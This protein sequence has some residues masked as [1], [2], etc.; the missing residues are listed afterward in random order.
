MGCGASAGSAYKEQHQGFLSRSQNNARRATDIFEEKMRFLR[1]VKLFNQL[2]PGDLPLIADVTCK[3]DFFPGALVVT[4]GEPGEEFFIIKSGSASVLVTIDGE[5]KK[6]TTLQAGDYFGEN[7]LLRDEPRTASIVA[8]TSLQTFKIRRADFQELG[9]NSKLKFASRR[10]IQ[11]ASGQSVK[12]RAKPPTPKTEQEI[13]FI[14]EALRNSDTLAAE[15]HVDAAT[16]RAAIALMWKEHFMAGVTIIKENDVYAD[17]FYI[18][19]SGQLEVSRQE[20]INPLNDATVKKVMGELRSGHIF[21]ELALM[22]CA[23]RDST[24]TAKTNSVV[25]VLDRGNFRRILMKTSQDKCLEYLKYLDAVPLLGTLL[26]E[27][28]MELAK[29]LFE[30]HFNKGE[31]IV[32]EG[33]WGSSFFILYEGKV[34]IATRA[35]G[36]VHTMVSNAHTRNMEYFGERALLGNERRGATATV[37]SEKAKC[38]MLDR[39]AFDTLLGPLR[40]VIEENVKSSQRKTR[41][42]SKDAP[43]KQTAETRGQDSKIFLKDLL[44]VGL[45]GCG[46]SASVELVEH[47]VTGETF[48]LKRISKGYVLKNDL[49]KNIKS[50][51]TVLQ[52]TNSPF[53]VRLVECYS[54]QTH[55]C[56]LL[57]A[58]MGGDLYA[59]YLRRGWYGSVRHCMHYA[60]SAILAL[61]HLHQRR[62]IYRDLKP[63]NLVLGEDGQVRLVDMGLA[64]F[65]VGKTYTTC[66]TPD[67]FSPEVVKAE[68]QTNAV[69]WWALG[70]LI[71]ELMSGYTPF[72]DRD[73]PIMTF[74]KILKGVQQVQFADNLFGPPEELIKALL[75]V[76]PAERLPMSNDGI[77]KLKDHLFFE[78]LNWSSL[79]S[80]RLKPPFKP[81][82]KHRRDTSNFCAKPEDVPQVIDFQHPGKD[83]DG[84][85]DTTFSLTD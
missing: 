58:A 12:T 35:S 51:K 34:E 23:P 48:A 61:E 7:A 5:E 18:V 24:V 75:K 28:K 82:L 70:I 13:H 52:M 9:L 56:Y 30:I 68:G 2:N 22:Y 66:G 57:E 1:E 46:G 79:A 10:G 11:G 40:Q 55:F 45:L 44:K 53:I 85:F 38:L 37:V 31:E 19:Q 42:E 60:A 72:E 54:T 27:E 14:A 32:R 43:T 15:I 80:H 17:Y 6:V 36:L 8:E 65:S 76:E 59:T 67:Y 21:G 49:I 69:D 64:K 4:Q 62:I 33:D 77:R 41:L 25:W 84:D 78:Q 74:S 83:W 26:A 3:Q 20:H 81:P 16:N 47:T 39:E 50:E 63:E 29:A 71:F 73:R